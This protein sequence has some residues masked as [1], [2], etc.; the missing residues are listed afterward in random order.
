MPIHK[1]LVRTHFKE[2]A[3]LYARVANDLSDQITAIGHELAEV[4]KAGGKIYIAGNGG[5]AADAQHFAAELAGRFIH[6]R[7]ALA[8]ICLSVDTSAL[9]AIGNDYGFDAVFARQ[10]QALARPEDAFVG[11]STSGRSP[12]ILRAFDACFEKGIYHTILLSGGDGGAY[13]NDD[14]PRPPK[15]TIVVPTHTTAH[16]QEVHTAICHTWCAIIETDLGLVD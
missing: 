4:L 11:I 7:P 5:S 12:N 10:I 2:G 6:D 9:T 8:G 15:H 16:I 3:D 14:H 13:I 1:E